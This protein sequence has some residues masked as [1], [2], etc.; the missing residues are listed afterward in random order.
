MVLGNLATLLGYSPRQLADWFWVAYIDAFDWV[1]EPNVMA[2]ATFGA[3]DLMTTKPYVSGAA[4]IDRMSDY[5]K[6]CRFDPKKNC[7]I[8]PLYWAFMHRHRTHL[9]KNPR[10]K[11]LLKN[12]EKRDVSEDEAVRVRLMQRL[13]EGAVFSE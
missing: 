11:L 10:V 1:V 5:C 4:Y 6:S 9:E 3:G 12:L 2:M 8:T 13:A 7:P